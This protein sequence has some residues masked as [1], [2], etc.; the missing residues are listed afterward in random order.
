MR[1]ISEGDSLVRSEGS[2]GDLR[3]GEWKEL[4]AIFLDKRQVR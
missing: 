1:E 3:I 4:E 2:G